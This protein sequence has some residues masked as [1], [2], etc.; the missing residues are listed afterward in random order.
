VSK[1]GITNPLLVC[2]ALLLV[3]SLLG[4]SSIAVVLGAITSAVALALALRT[5]ESATR[6]IRKRTKR[7]GRDVRAS[8][9]IPV[10]AALFGWALVRGQELFGENSLVDLEITGGHLW[11]WRAL[12]TTVAFMAAVIGLSSLVDWC[13]TVPRLAG[14]G[15]PQKVPC[16]TSTAEKWRGVTSLW[17][18]HRIAAYIVVRVGTLAAL[19]FLVAAFRPT[20]SQPI[21]TAIG[22]VAAAASVFFLNRLVPVAT[23]ASN[24]PMQVGD[25]V[26]LAEEHGTGV[27]RRPTYYV[28]DV[29]IEGVKLIEVANPTRR[30]IR[31][32]QTPDVPLRAGRSHDRTVGLQDIP[33]LLRERH[34]YIGCQSTCQGVNAYCPLKRGDP[35]PLVVP[36]AEPMSAKATAPTP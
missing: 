5:G 9:W 8:C 24:P 4:L 35:I 21:G 23:L 20:I 31:P 13:L 34:E 11:P 26:V 19:A 17:L 29:A 27:E 3:L 2:S 28:I 33:R 6:G 18:T 14:Y 36:P 16:R 1:S 7:D 30:R 12:V 32:L 25:K 10:L 15:D 22:A